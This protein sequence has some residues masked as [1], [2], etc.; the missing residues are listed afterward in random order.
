MPSV[1]ERFGKYICDITA[2]DPDKSRKLL[3]AAYRAYGAKLKLLP[4][5]KLPPSKQY[6][7]RYVN[8]VV[9]D[10]L[11]NPQDAALVS[12]FMPCELLTAM[13]IIPMCAELYS[14]FINGAWSESA[15]TR[16]AEEEGIAQTFCS[17]HKI[18]LGT[19][20]T[21][22]L[23]SPSMVVNTSLVCD[24]NNLTF[25]EL[26]DHYGIPQ[27]YLDVPSE[28]S[29]E[30]VAYVTEQLRELKTFLED[31][32]GRSLTEERLRDAV[33]RSRDT[34]RYLRKCFN[35][36]RSHYVANDVTSELYEIYMTHNALGTDEAYSYAK[37]LYHDLRNAPKKKGL[38]IL[39][40]HTVP[41]WQAPIRQ[42]MDVND[43][44]Q[45]VACDMNFESLIRMEPDK[46]YESMARRL[47]YSRWNGGRQRVDA[48]IK[49]AKA[50]DADGVI[51]FCHWGCKQ[52]MGLSAV[53]K[54]ALEDEGFPTLIL[55]GDGVDRANASDGQIS[56]R[57]NA[58]IEMLEGAGRG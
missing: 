25:R 22:V 24:A 23:K 11:S 38:R 32:S 26:S 18:L 28:R 8:K 57:L 43:R 27:Y 16:A 20:Y 53:F 46:P 29:K 55:N 30:A 9:T 35:E 41:N 42:L 14:C 51:C 3:L 17:Y 7:A 15:F 52:T 48:A 58:F 2:D 33:C 37:Q 21:G 34:I 44:C 36:K 1:A 31:N 39:W 6:S 13:D 54:S 47:I 4:N 49:A 45:L 12:V 5:K 56:T 19:A 10:M 40:L 50:L